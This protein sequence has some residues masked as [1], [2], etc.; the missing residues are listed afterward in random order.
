MADLDIPTRRT[1]E[2]KNQGKARR[3]ALPRKSLSTLGDRHPDFDPVKALEDQAGPRVP[4][5]VTT[6][7]QSAP[8]PSCGERRR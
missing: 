3:E 2:G 8:S 5:L 7:W 4:E 1:I 6:A